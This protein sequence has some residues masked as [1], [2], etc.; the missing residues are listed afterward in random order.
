MMSCQA[1]MRLYCSKA[2]KHCGGGRRE[3]NDE[4]RHKRAHFGY[5]GGFACVER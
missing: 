3:D 5:A 1:I 2:G 4:I